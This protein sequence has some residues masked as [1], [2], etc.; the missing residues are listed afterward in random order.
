MQYRHLLVASLGNHGIDIFLELNQLVSHRRIQSNHGR[1]TIGFGT[2]S[3]ELEAVSR[4]SKGRCAV[5]VG[6]IDKQFG[7]LGNIQAHTVF[8]A[9]RREI[10]IIAFLYM[11]EYL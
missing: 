10:V 5:T 9:E 2:D 7:Y 6:I 4:K 3:A 1:R 11:A 8:T